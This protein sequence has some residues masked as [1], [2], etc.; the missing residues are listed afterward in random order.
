MKP[1]PTF[2]KCDTPGCWR[3]WSIVRHFQK[4]PILKLC[5]RCWLGRMRRNHA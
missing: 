3:Q 1:K 4:R 2:S 5:A